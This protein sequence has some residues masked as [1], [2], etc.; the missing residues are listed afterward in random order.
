MPSYHLPRA[1]TGPLSR[2]T[3]RT[4]YRRLL[5]AGVNREAAAVLAGY[6]RRPLT[7]RQLAAH[8]RINQRRTHCPEC[9]QPVLAC[10]LA[11]HRRSA[12]HRY[13]RRTA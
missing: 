9:L 5:D 13:T 4:E 2:P 1:D 3:P 10:N 8:R 6:R 7:D 11:R 12:S